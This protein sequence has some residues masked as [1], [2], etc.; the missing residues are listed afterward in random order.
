MLLHSVL[1][2]VSLRRVN[3][4]KNLKVDLLLALLIPVFWIQSRQV[5]QRTPRLPEATGPREGQIGNGDPLRM[6]VIGDSGAAGVGVQVMDEALS[7]QLALL[8]SLD[9][10]VEWSVIAVNGLD[11]PGM[12][13]ILE[14]MPS[15]EFDVVVLSL[16]AND[17]TNLCPPAQWSNMQD[18]LAELIESRFKPRVLVHS[19][20]PPMHACLALPQPLRWF[21]GRWAL[22]MNRFLTESI[23]TEQPNVTGKKCK[24]SIHWHPASTT[25][26]G[27]SEDGIHPSA[28]GYAVW[29]QTLYSHIRDRLASQ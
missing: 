27:M 8:L 5:R 11:T 28:R 25:I 4:S 24:R 3:S 7:G 19:A 22:E 12:L 20:V 2:K 10:N 23:R 6:L 13:A 16:G 18:A 15:A 9:Y 29:A 17:A 1:A 14:N 26:D 21:M